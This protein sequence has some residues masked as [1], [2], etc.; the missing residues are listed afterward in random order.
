[1]AFK[2][3]NLKKS[4]NTLTGLVI[5]FLL[6]IGIFSGMFLFFTSK[7]VQSD[8]VIEEK[9]N[10]TYQRLKTQQT[11]LDAQMQKIET[12]LDNIK[13]A[14]TAYTVAWNGLKGLGNTLLLPIA[15]IS[16][17]VEISQ[18]IINPLGGIIPQW[19]ITLISIGI[20]AFL[21]FLI[22]AVL[23]GEPKM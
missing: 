7:A 3:I 5:T 13:E 21:I 16:T 11:S 1:M 6:V 10:D 14:D 2:K 8:I 22:L 12:N 19:V 15:L 17:G 23:K 4:A 18:A 9:Y 20:I